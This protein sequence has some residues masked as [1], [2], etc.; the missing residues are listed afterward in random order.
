MM[1]K[2][3]AA[4]GP[5]VLLVD[6]TGANLIALSAVL[7]PLGVRLVTAQSGA[8]ALECVRESSFA[9][10]L[11]D[12][13]MPEMDG[14]EVAR[15]MR[16]MENGRELPIIFV[17]AIH[18]DEA[19]AR[20]GYAVGAADYITKPFDVDILRARVRAFVDLY[21]QREEVRRA[22]VALRTRERDEALRRLGAIERIAT[23][24]MET[25]DV[26]SLLKE[27]MR[28]FLDGSDVTDCT[29][30]F[31]R[32]GDELRLAATLTRRG[33]N[34][35]EPTFARAGEGFVGTI[36]ASR[37]P[38]E[39]SDAPIQPAAHREWLDKRGARALFGM[40]LMSEG[41]VLGVAHIASSR[42]ALIPEREKRLFTAVCERAAWAIAKHQ[43]R[44][45]LH[46][47]LRTVPAMIAIFRGSQ[48][49]AEFLNPSCQSF[50]RADDYAGKRAD[51][52]GIEPNV[53]ALLR[54]VY[55]SGETIS[56]NEMPMQGRQAGGAGPLAYANLTLQPLHDLSGATQSVLV[57]AVDVT[58]QVRAR[59][60]IEAHQA[61]RTVLLERERAA[62]NEAELANRAKDQFLA[63]LSH[64]LRTPL[65][66]VLGWTARARAKAGPELERALSIVARNAEAQTRIVEDMLDLSRIISGKL[67][68]ELVPVRVQ[69]PVLGAVEAMRPSAEAKGVRIDVSV[70]ERLEVDGDP[71][72][73]QQIVWNLLSNAIKFTERGGHIGVCARA[74]GGRVQ[75]A[76]SDSGLGIAPEFL[77][78][79]FAPFAQADG[80]TTRRH[81]GLGLGLAIVQQLA[82]AHG[83]EVQAVSA[84]IGQGSTFLLELPLRA[85]TSAEAPRT[86]QIAI[87]MELRRTRPERLDGLDIVV[88]DDEWDARTMVSE[89][90]AELG[91]RVYAAASV[92]EALS[93]FRSKPPHVLIS[94][95]AMP[96]AD[97]YDLIRQVRN[98]PAQEGGRVKAIAL[99]AYAR[100][101][102]ASTALSAGFDRHMVKP[103]NLAMLANAV[104]ELVPQRDRGEA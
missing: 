5:S 62:R 47:I 76:V 15:R 81:G 102:D 99:T 67:R 98:L 29:S 46:A 50:L 89:A 16:D 56:A 48:H 65:N 39:L 6:D 85:L 88:V 7:S 31:L 8:E 37:R 3:Q 83:G 86:G 11:L 23:A 19:F 12:V 68:L 96:G 2:E 42:A 66:A 34:S 94:D 35:L 64:E 54:R 90:L 70:D 87:P 93:A 1:A 58:M 13:Q 52:L 28:T 49:V 10:A 95:I 80:S 25:N 20:R 9:V 72:R 75:I 84:G 32:A 17:T 40:P 22:Q 60:E 71:V 33:E 4:Q 79:V 69:D 100:P 44:S 59:Q 18:R 63:T 26:E 14:F 101:E 38:L 61:E 78:Q 30:V 104:A 91:A 73:L 55:D 92:S 51:E 97:G 82:L 74:E 24:A 103:V 57:F 27:L 45:R 36:A 21:H 43:E 77:P 53:L 41:E